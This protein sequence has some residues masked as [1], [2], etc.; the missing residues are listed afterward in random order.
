V[1]FKTLEEAAADER[2]E[3]A[4]KV[5]RAAGFEVRLGHHPAGAL[6]EALAAV[7]EKFSTEEKSDA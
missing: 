4:E 5:L 6:I 7:A 2:A 1:W 3:A